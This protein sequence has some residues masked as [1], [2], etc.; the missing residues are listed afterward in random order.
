MDVGGLGLIL[1]IYHLK[2]LPFDFASSLASY[3]LSHVL[4]VVSS[5]D[6]TAVLAAI[7]EA[8]DQVYRQCA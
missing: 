4:R 6:A 1:N 7:V 8:I 5:I 2:T 3:S